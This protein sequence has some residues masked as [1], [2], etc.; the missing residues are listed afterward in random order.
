MDHTMYYANKPK[1]THF[2]S[3]MDRKAYCDQDLSLNLWATQKCIWN[4]SPL[5]PFILKVQIK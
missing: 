3:E 2:V 1:W 4:L 5:E